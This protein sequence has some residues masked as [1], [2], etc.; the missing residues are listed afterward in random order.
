MATDPTKLIPPTALN[1]GAQPQPVQPAP[2]APSLDRS[3]LE[4]MASGP[5]VNPLVPLG[6]TDIRKAS[7]EGASSARQERLAG[8]SERR[9]ALLGGDSAAIEREAAAA[10]NGNETDDLRGLSWSE[11]LRVK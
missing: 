7:V 3:T 10:L 6:A 4:A 2:A 9:R 8:A 5:Q 11:K 1:W